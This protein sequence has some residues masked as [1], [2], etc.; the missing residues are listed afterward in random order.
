MGP[1]GPQ[2]IPGPIAEGGP[3]L[4]LAGGTVTGQVNI[5]P[6]LMVG[7]GTNQNY[8]GATWTPQFWLNTNIVGSTTATGLTNVGQITINADTL[9]ASGS[10]GKLI[11]YFGLNASFGGTAM[12]GNRQ[13]IGASINLASPSGNPGGGNYVGITGQAMASASDNGT[14]LTLA[15]CGG[16]LF[17]ANFYASTAG[18]CQN[19]GGV[20]GIEVN[21]ALGVGTTAISLTGIQVV[22]TSAHAV[23]G[24]ANWDVGYLLSAQPGAQGIDLGYLVGGAYGGAEW[25][26][27]SDGSLFRGAL[28][29]SGG[30]SARHGVMLT[31]V[32]F[33]VFGTGAR[34]GAFV[35]NGFAVDG[36][37]TIQCGAG[38]ITPGATLG[39]DVKG[40]IGTGTPTVAAGGNGYRVGDALYDPYGGVYLVSAV[41][42]SAV[43]GVT[44]LTGAYGE[45]HQPLFPTHTTPTNPV[46]T[47][48][49]IWAAGASGCTLNLT[50]DTSRTGLS[51][52]PSGGATSAGGNLNVAGLATF[53]GAQQVL[54]TQ[55]GGLNF[56][57]GNGGALVLDAV[58]P[59]QVGWSN[60]TGINLNVATTFQANVGFYTTAPI[61]KRTGWGAATGTATR[62][63]FLTSSVTLPVL[64]EHVKALIDDL[65]AYGLIGP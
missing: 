61:A 15:T 51:L 24:A 37:G 28:S 6:I 65:I 54:I 16:A 55:S 9:D 12:K 25:P 11:N 8:S 4:P 18:A 10:A 60:A 58:G 5:S 21:P 13:G 23:R 47:T 36:G 32:S 40:S 53:G 42:G 20:I 49:W 14:G 1:P 22:P 7:T 46:T 59:V 27:R 57:Q 62:S 56:V 19:F 48:T 2:G 29:Y 43:T 50:W 30:A 52:Q 39:I 41:S 64:A 33:P 26:I 38:Y 31:E 3:F 44:V 17:G 35:S 34:G 63:T 45:T